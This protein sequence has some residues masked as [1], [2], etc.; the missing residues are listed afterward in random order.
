VSQPLQQARLATILCVLVLAYPAVRVMGLVPL[1]TLQSV[2]MDVF[3]EERTESLTFRIVHE[4]ALMARGLDRP[5]FG[6][7]KWGRSR[8]HNY[9][10]QDTSVTDGLYIRLFGQRGAIALYA[11]ML[12]LLAPC[13]AASRAIARTRRV[14]V[15]PLA[16]SLCLVSALLGL[17]LIFNGLHDY[18]QFVYAALLANLASQL[19]D[20]GL[21]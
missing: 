17:D 3:G 2:T 7:G 11:Y 18:F 6:W 9:D 19:N 20:N 15:S 13:L 21:K 14:R 1:D 10:G 16:A 4:D 8:I 5:V 12:I